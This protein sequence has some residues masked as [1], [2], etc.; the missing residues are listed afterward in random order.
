MA[1]EDA[2]ASWHDIAGSGTHLLL[3]RPEAEVLL[4][5]VTRQEAA[6]LSLA[7][8]PVPFGTLLSRHADA[9]T[10]L[11]KTGALRPLLEIVP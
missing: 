6:L 5:R 1:L 2:A 9:A 3:T 4:T 11:V 10:T 7:A 8:R